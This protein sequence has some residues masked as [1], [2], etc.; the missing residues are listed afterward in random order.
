MNAYLP[1]LVPNQSQYKSVTDT[2]YKSVITTTTKDIP[3]VIPTNKTV[4]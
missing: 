3:I 1:M 2:S 4:I